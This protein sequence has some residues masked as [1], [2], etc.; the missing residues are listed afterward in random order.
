[1]P[2]IILPE[3][4]LGKRSLRNEGFETLIRTA[5]NIPEAL[6]I[7]LRNYQTWLRSRDSDYA[8]TMLWMVENNKFPKRNQI[9]PDLGPF[10]PWV[11]DVGSGVATRGHYVLPIPLHGVINE[12]VPQAIDLGFIPTWTSIRQRGALTFKNNSWVAFRSCR[13]ALGYLNQALI[14]LRQQPQPGA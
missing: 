5:W 8:D 2:D 14:I 6:N 11:F 9:D 7:H 3:V 1:M 13:L 12:I 4:A 10:T